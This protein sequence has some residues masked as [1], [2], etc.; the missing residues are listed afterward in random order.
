[1]LPHEGA[2]GTKEDNRTAL[3]IPNVLP[4]L[5]LICIFH[6]NVLSSVQQA[7]GS[8]VQLL[9]PLLSIAATPAFMDADDKCKQYR[10]GS[11]G[12]RL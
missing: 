12:D 2:W 7:K 5:N 3:K 1:M 11:Q 4:E 8:V 6:F 9:H 10:N